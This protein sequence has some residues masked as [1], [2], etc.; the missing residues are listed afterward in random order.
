[1]TALVTVVAATWGLALLW[2]V[3][4]LRLHRRLLEADPELYALLGRP[5]M[6]WLWWSAPEPSPGGVP[7]LLKLAALAQGSLELETMSSPAEI[8]S[9][10]KLLHWIVRSRP[11]PSLDTRCRRLQRQL[12]LC[13]IG[14][15]IGCCLVVILAITATSG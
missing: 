6:R 12:R 5:V 13:G 8:R 7:P 1:M 3:L 14:F 15:G 4:M 11:R 9:K 2:L 10:L